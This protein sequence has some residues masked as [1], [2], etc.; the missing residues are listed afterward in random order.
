MKIKLK[1]KMQLVKEEKLYMILEV[2]F[3]YISY[4]WLKNFNI[5][6]IVGFIPI[7]YPMLLNRGFEIRAYSMEA[8][9]VVLCVIAIERLKNRINYKNI[10][11]LT[12]KSV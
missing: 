3:I 2:T 11:Y 9:G 10:I 7:L 4:I 5:A 12:K 1:F 6:L 8:L